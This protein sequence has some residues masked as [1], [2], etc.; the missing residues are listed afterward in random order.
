MKGKASTNAGSF[1]KG[2]KRPGQGRPKGV[3]NKVTADLRAAILESFDRL[4]GVGYLVKVGKKNQNAY[5]ALVGKVIPT[6]IKGEVKM[7][8]AQLVM[9]SMKPRE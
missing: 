2:E 1:K 8:F 6:E 4:G 3:P 9:E 5:L 7:S